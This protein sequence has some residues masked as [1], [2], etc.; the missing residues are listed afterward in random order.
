MYFDTTME[1]S[2]LDQMFFGPET[3]ASLQADI[4]LLNSIFPGTELEKKHTA[5]ILRGKMHMLEDAFR[6]KVIH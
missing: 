3:I 2:A 4:I 5:L 1:D 6:R